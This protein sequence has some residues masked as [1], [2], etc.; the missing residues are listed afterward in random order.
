[1]SPDAF[2]NSCMTREDALDFLAGR[3]PAD[4]EIEI[5]S[6]MQQCPQCGDRIDRLSDDPDLRNAFHAHQHCRDDLKI[7]SSLDEFREEMYA[8]DNSAPSRLSETVLSNSPTPADRESESSPIEFPDDF[9]RFRI[10]RRL[11]KGGFGVVYLADDTLLHR[12]VALKIPRLTAL[13]DPEHRARFLREGRATAGLYHPHILPVYE[14]GEEDGLCYLTS[15]YCS[16]PTLAKWLREHNGPIAPETAAQIISLLAD[17]IQHAHQHGVLHLDVKPSNVLLDTTQSC[18]SLPF[19]P[20]LADFGLAKLVDAVLTLTASNSMM[21]TPR[22]MAPEQATGR[23]RDIGPATDVY[24]L[25]V[26]LYELITGAV[27]IEGANHADTLRRLLTDLP[28]SPRKKVPRIPVD[29]EAIC[30]KCL[31]KSPE[32]RYTT[33]AELA[34]DLKRFLLDGTPTQARPMPVPARMWRWTKRNPGPASVL[35]TLSAATAVVWTLILVH[36]HSIDTIN[37][38]LRNANLKSR[39][40]QRQSK[41]NAQKAEQ[42][43]QRTRQFLYAADMR[44]AD[45]AWRQGDVQQLLVFLNRHRPGP[46]E[47]DSR[48][49]EWYLLFRSAHMKQHSVLKCRG[50]V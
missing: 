36:S 26:V 40:S 45:R 32:Q 18:G 30:M 46:G 41:Q 49:F 38:N 4:R 10:H 11:G 12:K 8:L 5:E 47:P 20:L 29:L 6:H 3:L 27:P 1:M 19:T 24:A 43:E 37:T 42:S 16:G 21:G 22:Y 17:A 28:V 2:R 33:A 44:L 9:G 13:D 34:A 35:L 39:E 14:A 50:D 25:G 7:E 48:G 31:E 15:L 23:N